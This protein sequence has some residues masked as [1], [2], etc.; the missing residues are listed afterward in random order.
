VTADWSVTTVEVA[1][2]ILG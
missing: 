1:V 2:L